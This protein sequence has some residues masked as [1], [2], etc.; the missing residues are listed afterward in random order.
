MLEIQGNLWD[1]Y[2]RGY[3]VC[4]TTNGYVNSRGQA[5]MGRG[6]ALEAVQRFPG[7]RERLAASISTVGN[8][9]V[10]FSNLRLIIFPVKH[11]WYQQADIKLIQRSCEQLTE[12]MNALPKI[13][14]PVILPRPGCGNGG[15]EWSV[16]REE[17]EPLLDDRVHIITF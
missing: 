3:W 15:L 11:V 6:S 17:V 7:I 12:V 8:R 4:I 5:V 2:D 1:Y 10:L 13:R 16:V 14:P 9:L